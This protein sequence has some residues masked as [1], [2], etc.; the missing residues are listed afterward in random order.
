MTSL[1]IKGTCFDEES[2]PGGNLVTQT[3]L[4]V[5]GINAT[6]LFDSSFV[7]SFDDWRQEM[8]QLGKDADAKLKTEEPAVEAAK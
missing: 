5:K 4:F 1:G 3:L 2:S 6:A 7:E 8:L